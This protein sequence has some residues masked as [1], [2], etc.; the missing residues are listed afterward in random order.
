[1]IAQHGGLPIYAEADFCITG[2]VEAESHTARGAVWRSPGLLQPGARISGVEGRAGLASRRR[3]L[4]VHGGR[5]AAAGRHDVRPV[6]SR[7]DRAGH[8]ER[9]SRRARACTRST[10]PGV[11]PLLLAIGSERYTPYAERRRPQELLTHGQRD[12]GA[13]AALAGQVSVDRRTRGRRGVGHARRR[14][15]VSTHPARGSTGRATCIFR[16]APRSTRSTIRAAAL[17][18]GSKLVI[19]AVGPPVRELPSEVGSLQ[20][21]DGFGP[22]RLC[23]PG[24]L[25]VAGPKYQL[26][27]DG[28]DRAIERFCAAHSAAAPINRFPLLVVVDDVEFTARTAEQFSVGHVHAQ[29]SGGRRARHRGVHGAKTLG[30]PRIAGDRRAD[31]AAARA[32]AGRRCCGDAA[33]RRAGRGR[34]TA[35]GNFLRSGRNFMRV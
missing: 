13:G 4:A 21:P 33:R 16:R 9:D 26:E 15:H 12:S 19:A 2:T 25:A 28:T 32:A 31:E 30:L 29:Q 20:L 35:G 3:D 24:V 27:G 8:S 34:R 5:P 1:M 7:A 11:H 18:E 10:R 6:D 14:S 22:A 23:M 17:N